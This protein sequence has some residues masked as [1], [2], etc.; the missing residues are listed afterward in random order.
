MMLVTRPG[1]EGKRLTKRLQEAGIP[2]IWLP[3]LVIGPP[4]DP[5]ACQKALARA[6]EYDWLIFVSPAAVRAALPSLP[7]GPLPSP[8]QI[9]ALGPGSAGLLTAAGY[10]VAAFPA[11]HC[12]TES[13]LALLPLRAVS[14][15]HIGLIQGKGGR[16][17]LADSLT[18]Q[19]AHVT[20]IVAYRRTCPDKTDWPD[21]ITAI[22][23]TS[24]AILQNLVTCFG[25]K[26]LVVPLTVSSMRLAKQAGELGFRHIHTA[27]DASEA[28]LLA[29]LA[30]PPQEMK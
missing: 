14:G 26:V 13:L 12:S 9:A 27:R 8:V 21:G 30:L 11:T 6:D 20:H 18:Q 1:P 4:P 5:A 23:A 22:L 19:G 25:Q 10:A 29:Q 17:L 3:L 2:A 15:K 24:G 16:T 7:Q 28:G